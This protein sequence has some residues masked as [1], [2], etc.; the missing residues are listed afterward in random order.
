MVK[1]RFSHLFCSL[2]VIAFFDFDKITRV[3]GGSV[4][5]IGD[6]EK[7]G[8]LGGTIIGVIVTWARSAK[9]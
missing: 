3:L 5:R 7:G 1:R 4:V 6:A 8:A 9:S 2:L